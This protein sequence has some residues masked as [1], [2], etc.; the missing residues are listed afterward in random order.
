MDR[1]NFEEH[2]SAYIDGELSE[3]E[4]KEFEKLQIENT[5]KKSRIRLLATLTGPKNTGQE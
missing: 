3:V 4:K 2:I 1:Y 5:N